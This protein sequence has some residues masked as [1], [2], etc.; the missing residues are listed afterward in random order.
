[1]VF[2]GVDWVWMRCLEGTMRLEGIE[3]VP[4]VTMGPRNIR[5]QDVDDE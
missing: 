5:K 3:D 2:G 1:M 4:A